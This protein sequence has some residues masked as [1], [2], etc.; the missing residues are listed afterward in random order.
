MANVIVQTYAVSLFEVAQEEKKEEL[1]AWVRE[2]IRDG[3]VRAI[4]HA[5][6][7]SHELLNWQEKKTDSV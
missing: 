7:R 4:D 1:P 2:R 3:A 6:P 5:H